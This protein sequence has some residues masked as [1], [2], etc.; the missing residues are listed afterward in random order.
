[1]VLFIYIYSIYSLQIN[2]RIK[3]GNVENTIQEK[4]KNEGGKGKDE[5]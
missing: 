2:K 4:I 5:G 3:G 1:M